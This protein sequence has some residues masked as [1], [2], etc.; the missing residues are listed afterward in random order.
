MKKLL[1][2]LI[3]L[4]IIG[5]FSTLG[6]YYG[7]Y[8]IHIEDVTMDLKV[9]TNIGFNTRT[10]A[11][12]FGTIFRG[13]TSERKLTISNTNKFPVMINI[14]NTGNCS[15]F[16]KVND[17]NVILQPSNNHTIVYSASPH[18][19]AGYGIYNGTSTVTVKRKVW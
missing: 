19:N 9:G 7:L 15:Q 16:V 5:I 4:V 12:H 10:D 2:S 11:L 14:E 8:I 1:F 3:L 17:N 18:M 13:G 6:M